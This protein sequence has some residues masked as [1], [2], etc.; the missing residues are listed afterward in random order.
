MN[1]PLSIDDV[2]SGGNGINTSGGWMAALLGQ[3][4]SNT[5]HSFACVAFGNVKEVQVEHDDRIDS[6]VVPGDLTGSSLDRDLL[7]YQD[8]VN[9]WQPDLIHIHGTEAAYGLLI[10]RNMVRC[11]AVIS[12]QGLLGPYSEWYRFFGNS[13]FADIFRMHR[14]QEIIA[15][16]GQMSAFRRILKLAKREREIIAGNRFFMGRTAWDQAYIRALNPS[17]RYFSGGE[18]LRGAF[19]KRKWEIGRT[20]RHRIIFT[21][22]GHPRKGT[23]T[24]LD[25]VKLLQ[26]DFPDIQVGIAGGINQ[27]SGYGRYIRA[28]LAELGSLAIELGPLKPEEMVEELIN[29]HVFVSPSYIDNS[30]NAVCEAQLLGMPVVSTYTGGVPSL[31]EEGRTGLFFPTGDAPMLAARLREVFENESLAVRLGSQ[32]HEVA[33]RRHDPDAVLQEIV[34]AYEEVLRSSAGRATPPQTG[35]RAVK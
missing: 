32:A 6:F 11:P 9:R 29:S 5:N 13:S 34:T 20:R 2:K 23:E 10:T 25:A 26:A 33:V 4:L 12:L 22:A 1:T 19:W 17:A 14:W 16:R 27:R 15:M 8:V 3:M 30:P 31:I 28:R 7:A 21:N 24:L 35:N 18:L